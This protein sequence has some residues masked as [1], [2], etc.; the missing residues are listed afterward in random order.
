[1]SFSL[2]GL[3]QEISPALLMGLLA[4]GVVAAAVVVAPFAGSVGAAR[5]RSPRKIGRSIS[6]RCRTSP[7]P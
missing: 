3:P 5:G 4:A 6:P 7:G 2:P 1:M